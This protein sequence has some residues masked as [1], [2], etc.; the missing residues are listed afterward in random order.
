[1]LKCHYC[2][3]ILLRVND[4]EMPLY[5]LIIHHKRKC[6]TLVIFVWQ[7]CKAIKSHKM[8]ND[9]YKKMHAEINN[10]QKKD[11]KQ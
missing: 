11:Q 3:T 1:M 5:E 6:K 7:K 4:W 2:K 9:Y 8:K 10:L